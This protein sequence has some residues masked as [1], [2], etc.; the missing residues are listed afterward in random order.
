MTADIVQLFNPATDTSITKADQLWTRVANRLRQQ[1]FTGKYAPGARLVE[2]RIASEI[3]VAQSSVREA[4]HQLENEG[5]ITRIP[6]IGASVTCLSPA[7][8]E[9]IY[10]LRAQL[11]GYAVELVGGK[12]NP[13]DVEG[14]EARIAG[15]LAEVES[16]PLDFM[17][18]DLAFHVDLWTRSGNEFLLETLSRLVIPLFAFE[19][20]NIVPDLSTEVRLRS[21][22]SHKIVVD[23]LREGKIAEA[24]RTMTEMIGAFGAQ[25]R[26]LS[27]A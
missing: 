11:E 18:A 5:L 9:Q 3:G 8:V 1:I 2:T 20:R 22:E 15:W 25:T 17:T 23:L 26:E 13:E 27:Q 16:S 12:A 24:R 21:V 10:G 6:N 4:L 14:L 7:Q 19:T